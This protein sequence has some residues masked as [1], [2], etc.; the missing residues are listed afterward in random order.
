MRI[1]ANQ[2]IR[3]MQNIINDRYAD[4][5][6]LQEESATGKRLRKPSDD[7]VG[8]ANDLKL[9]TDIAGLTQFQKNISDGLGFMSVTDT[10]MNSMN[11]LLQ[12]MRELAVQG[13]TDTLTSTE[14]VYLNKEVEQLTRQVASLINTQYK[15]DY[16]FSGTQTKISPLALNS[17]QGNTAED[18]ANLKMAYYNAAGAP[19]PATVQLFNGFDNSAI[20]DIIPGSFNLKVGAVSYTENVDYTVDYK[21]GTITILNPALAVNT[22]PG[23]ANYA[24]GQFKITFD[25]LAKGKDVFGSTVSNQGTVMREIEHGITA[26]INISADEFM[27][28]PAIGADL[29]GTM[30]G[31]GQDLLQ[32]NRAGVSTAIDT[33]D[34]TMKAVIA[35]Q[36]KNGSRVNRFEATQTRNDGQTT[37]ATDLQ[38]TIEDAE[39]TTTITNYMNAQNV[40][41]S[42]LKSA[43]GV[44]QQSLVNFL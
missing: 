34:A 1:T 4:L 39:M 24:V 18:Y 2:I 16:V 9:K 15:G 7:P 29:I 41:N 17:S 43:A 10:A 14:R 12:R 8:V 35:A 20:Q 30:I 5:T 11:D 3:N 25:S 27:N 23:T 22:G 37:N 40:Y 36:G 13:S 32:N 26:P 44:I 19:V 31:L 42:A 21:N 28:N 33:L 6:H 38:S